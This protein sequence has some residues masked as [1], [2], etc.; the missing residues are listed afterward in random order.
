MIDQVGGRL[1]HAP[2]TAAWREQ[3]TRTAV[4]EFQTSI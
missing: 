4:F 2:G 3:E 1:D